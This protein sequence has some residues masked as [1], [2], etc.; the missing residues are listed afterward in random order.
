MT[1]FP[2]GC[3]SPTDVRLGVKHLRADVK[4]ARLLGPPVAVAALAGPK[5]AR[6]SARALRVVAWTR[7]LLG[8]VGIVLLQPPAR[9]Q[10]PSQN[11]WVTD[12]DVRAVAT[13]GSIVY[14]GGTFTRVGPA[15]GSALAW[16]Q[17]SGVP[18]QPYPMIVGTVNAV[19]PDGSG[20]WYVGG[21]FTSV[22]GQPRQNLAH[23]DPDGDLAS[24][25]PGA[26]GGISTLA[27]SGDAVYAGGSFTSIGGQPRNY[28]AALDAAS[29]AT[30]PWNPNANSPVTA[31]SVSAG[32]VY[33]GG[34]FTVIGGQA[35]DHVAALDAS[36]GLATPWYPHA[37]ENEIVASPSS[38]D[39]GDTSGYPSGL[40]DDRSPLRALKELGV[41][42]LAV[43]GGTVYIGGD[44]TSIAGVARNNIAALDAATGT[45]TSWNP[46][47]TGEFGPGMGVLA[48][49]VSDGTVYT[50]G[51]FTGF[52][53]QTRN[54]IA[55][56]DSVTGAATSWNPN[57][58][59]WV[60]AL[61]VSGG[62]VYAGGYFTNIGGQARQYMAALDATTGAATSWHSD[63]NG[64]VFA[65]AAGVGMVYAGGN[66][67]SIGGEIRNRIAALDAATGTATSWNPGA[68]GSLPGGV[69]ALALSG[70]TIYAGGV[71]STIGG[72]ARSNIA[73]LDA[74]TGTATSWDPEANAAVRSLAVSGGTVYAG[75]DFTSIGGK[76]RNHIAALH[77]TTGRATGW[78]PSANSNVYALAVSKGTVYVGG[79]FTSI[80]GQ[81]R[82]HIAA[83]DAAGTATGWDPNAADPTGFVLALVVSGETVY[84]GGAYTTIGGRARLNIAALDAATGQASPWD[85]SPDSYVSTVAVSGGT[86]YIGGQ[87]TTVAG[88]ARNHIAA[89]D[90]T[91]GQA[92]AW[93][94]DADDVVRSLALSGGTV[95]A[96]GS[97]RGVH[98]LPFSFF[99]GISE[100]V[101]GVDEPAADAPTSRLRASPNPF[102]TGVTLEFTAP[103]ADEADFAVYE[104]SGRLV[105]RLHRGALV[106]GAQRFTW[107]GTNDGGRA[108]SPGLYLV[109]VQARNL[110]LVTKV[111]RIR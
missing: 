104:I 99:A 92:T 64:A 70:G 49:A 51:T 19:A 14:L 10:V 57:A 101:L 83:L 94:P 16:M 26:D 71:F 9:A 67:S 86:V 50:G 1:R 37:N 28:I 63:A 41:L 108:V 79:Q 77:A 40:T 31:V 35:R 96:G 30:T 111:L 80:G 38:G 47:A 5:V 95:Y 36:T 56:L 103:D 107:D 43:S 42:A 48:L 55:A 72:Q 29:G 65:L 2:I 76:A 3:P 17:G 62:T 66:F 82:N 45:V 106:A 109:R 27:V 68:S 59:G 4:P 60:Y 8:L 89:I 100:G 33:A 98:A 46:G 58:N 91:Q 90:A 20:G 53:G 7:S 85:P 18:R 24:W 25:D 61:A 97:F 102:H 22:L 54:R 105:R 75:G 13:S 84:A 34:L 44:F 74:A 21:S 23:L 32:T 6:K 69:Y 15:T 11:L 87:F 81:A 93:N 88:Q 110:S 52:A 12:G 73:A 39:A 78:N